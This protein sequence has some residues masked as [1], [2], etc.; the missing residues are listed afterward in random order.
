MGAGALHVE[1]IS[2]EFAAAMRVRGDASWIPVVEIEF[3]A[4]V[5]LDEAAAALRDADGGQC[6]A[7]LVDRLLGRAVE[8]LEALQAV[9]VSVLSNDTLTNWA[10][11]VEALRRRIESVGVRV[12][13]HVDTA[14]PFRREGF[15]TAQA[16]L[17]HRL[18][19]SGPEAYR[20]VQTAR[21][22]RRLYRWKRAAATARVGVAQSALMARVA[23]NPRLDPVVLQRGARELCADAE[24]LSYVE[25]EHNVHRFEALAD[26]DGDRAQAD[27]NRAHRDADIRPRPDG[28]FTVTAALDG[29]AGAEFSDIFGHFVENEWRIDWAEARDRLGREPTMLDLHRTAS[30]RRAD[31]FMAMARA[32]AAAPPWTKQALPTVN[33]LIDH[34][35]YDATLAG[36]PID[37]MRYRD[38]TCRS[39]AGHHLHPT[40]VVNT[41]LIGHIRR[42]VHDSAKVIINLGRRQRLFTGSAREAVMLL[43]TTCAWIGCD[44]PTDW[45]Q[46]DHSLSWKA[47][48]NTVPRN[49]SPLCG[50]HNNLKERGYTITRDPNGAWH[51]HGPDGH[52]II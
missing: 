51:T 29:C 25:F 5:G 50:R 28:G 13:D 1:Q 47:H 23:A 49:G 31:A 20:R 4:F 33:Y 22:E 36:E 8:S 34:A 21:M 39:Q 26:P 16:W 35:T 3:A 11:T 10:V 24:R 37:P 44:T 42:V 12:A 32:A 46:A 18:Q 43:D 14:R 52:E 45:C 38:I 30:Q 2:D 9:D 48:G 19:L 7:E 41:S 27:Q 17:K 40:D 15:F 6:Q